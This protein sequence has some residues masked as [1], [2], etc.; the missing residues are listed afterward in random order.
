MKPHQ[1][2]AAIGIDSYDDRVARPQAVAICQDILYTIAVVDRLEDGTPGDIAIIALL[3]AGERIEY[4]LLQLDSL[5]VDGCYGRLKAE[6]VWVVPEY[7]PHA[8]FS[9]AFDRMPKSV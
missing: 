7:S 8:P 3:A 1:L 2:E 6:T 4:R 5:A 9:L